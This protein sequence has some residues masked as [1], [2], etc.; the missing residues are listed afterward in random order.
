MLKAYKYRI[1]PTKT[2][3]TLIEKHFGSCRFLYNYFLDYRQKEYAKGNKKINYNTTQ[4]ELTKLK[5]KEEFEWLNECGSQ[6]LQMSLRNLDGAFGRFFKKLGAYPKFHSKKNTHQSF[7]VPQNIKV[8]NNRVYFPK[9]VKDGIKTKIHREIPENKTLKQATISRQNNQYFIS[10][11]IDD[12][13]A[14]PKPIKAK[15]AVGIDMGLTNLLITSDGVKYENKKYT[16]KS[17]KKLKKLQKK[18]SKKQHSRKKGDTTP[19]SS[20]YKKA[21]IKVQKLHTKIANQRKDYLHKISNEITNQYDIICLETLHVKGLIKNKRLA[22]GIADVAWSE[23]MRQLEYKSSWRGKTVIKIDKW[24]PSSQ[25]CAVC[26]SSTGKKPLNIRKFDCPHCGAKNIDRD[27]NAS[28]NI[29]NYGIGQLDNRNTAGT[30]E[31][32]ACGVSSD[33]VVVYNNTATSHD[34]MKQEAQSSLA[35]G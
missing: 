11:L 28:I 2:Q 8:A 7:T 9:F 17:Q 13:I 4:A 35:V 10:I 3:I 33:G 21:K 1:Y 6:A 23:F 5:K 19:Q 22:K 12:G 29:R 32:Q 14:L 26:G 25:I 27:I 15:N 16:I 18:L 34:T 30:V 20:N 24:F 31:I